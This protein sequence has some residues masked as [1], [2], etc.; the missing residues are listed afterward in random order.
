MVAVIGWSIGLLRRCVGT[1]GGAGDRSCLA[2]SAILAVVSLSVLAPGASAS[3]TTIN[4]ETPVI[5]G[6]FSPQAGPFL[7]DQYQSE[8]VLFG[9]SFPAMAQAIPL[10]C[11]GDIYRDDPNAHSGDQVAF[12]FCP[13][14]G[15]NFDE[16]ANISGEIPDL[17]SGV[18]V[19]AGSPGVTLSGIHY[20]GG[21]Q[22]T[23]L[24]GY[25]PSGQPIE[26]DSA[27]VG[28]G[29]RTLLSIN[30]SNPDDVLAY[31]SVS[32]PVA[33]SVPLEI[34]DLGFVVPSTPYS[35]EIAVNPV[36][37]NLTAGA[38]GHNISV[39]VTIDRYAGADQAIT[40]SISGLPAGVTLTGGQT[41][42]AD[43]DSTDLSFS[44]ASNAHV[45]NPTYTLTAS[46]ADASSASVQGT[47]TVTGGIVLTLSQ[48]SLSTAACSTATV[49]VSTQQYVAGSLSLA[50]S[51]QGDT[52]GLNESLS[53]ITNHQATL[54]LASNGTGGAGTATYTF[55]LSNPNVPPETATLVVNRIGLTTQGVYVTQGTQTDTGGLNPSG[56]ADSGDAYSG[57]TLVAN[58]KTVVRVYADA[59]GSPAVEAQLYGYQFG[60]PLPGSPLE[61]DYGPLDSSGNPELTLPAAQAAAGET[62]PD[63]Q[64]ESNANAYTFTLPGS[65]TDATP[66]A[67]PI[68]L[69]GQVAPL[70]GALI[71]RCHA[72]DSFTLNSVP[73]SEVGNDFD[74]T[75]YPLAMTVNGVFPPPPSQVFQDAA[76]VTP[77]A[78]GQFEV[79][80]YL[81]SVDISAIANSTQGPCGLNPNA[82]AVYSQDPLNGSNSETAG[83]ACADIKDANALSSVQSFAQGYQS[84]EDNGAHVVGVN[85]GVARGLTNGV[86]GQYSVVDGTANYRPLTSVTHELF[87]QFGLQHASAACGGGGVNWPPDQVG[88]LDGIGLNTTSEPYDF[89][90]NGSPDVTGSARTL[91]FDLM[92]YCAHAGGNDPNTW[93]SPRNWQQLI[94][95]FGINCCQA[96]DLAGGS[97]ST[98]N[99]S[100]AGGPLAA[101]A[102][103]HRARLSV[104]G[105]VTRS[106]VVITNVGPQVGP[107]PPAGSAADSFTL[108]ALGSHGQVLASV[109]MAATT[110]GHIDAAAGPIP[111]VQISGD[112][113]SAGVDAIV[114]EDAGRVV[115]TRKRPARPPRVRLL[116]PN[117]DVRVGHDRRVLVRWRSTD[118]ERLP[119]R[120]MLDYSRNGGRTWRTI[121]VG[122]G[123]GQAMLPGFYFTASHEARLRV[124]VNDGFNETDAESVDFTALGASPVVAITTRLAP[125]LVVP[126]D[127][128][129]LLS[130]QA[131]DQAADVL[132]GHSLRWYDG[133]FLLGTGP[134]ITAG[135]FPE[136]INHIRLVARDPAGRTSFATLAVPVSRVRLPFLGLLIPDHVSA[137]ATELTF[138]GA[139]SIP[140]SLTIGNQSFQVGATVKTF[141]LPITPGSTPLLLHLTATANGITTPFAVFVARG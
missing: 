60:R 125:T 92:S 90:A 98:R 58:K 37:P 49:T 36:A 54:T 44:I 51:A 43:S 64:L 84:G 112:V 46:T 53:P 6:K 136:G 1:C 116:Y 79:L 96:A 117:K 80:P 28:S 23:T 94:S 19:Y 111:L 39:P 130:G 120:A 24:T 89:I 106:R 69:V 41:I 107:P 32:G 123:S 109:P 62:V 113:P 2:V 52:N 129:L 56:T 82:T 13:A 18:S 122:P 137:L 67:S 77:I 126:G 57:V 86:P 124:R 34:D 105:F 8:G 59:T 118:P 103:V 66:A 9:S 99:P 74:S 22:L 139:A 65:W 85:L 20:P 70:G 132:Q 91:A 55:T 21:G 5:A 29:A 97:R 72:S 42:P 15:E 119:L 104:I 133:P 4:F 88:E 31:F 131:V 121:F 114:I 100:A 81:A 30:S 115:A 61:P 40:L 141:S 10:P 11:G 17:T 12:S 134:A 75:V 127:A 35:P 16:D 128:R 33:T 63:S 68:Q 71:S 27:V 45:S 102:R 25:A 93:V 7:G 138:P 101:L 26:S 110:G 78:N 3:T 48:Y 73:F 14:E 47:F 87:H 38:Q 83:A 76:A 95:N 108:K 140:T 50:V 135:P